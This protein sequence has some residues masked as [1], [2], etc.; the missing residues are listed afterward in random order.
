MSEN[1][2]RRLDDAAKAIAGTNG[3]QRHEAIV[4]FLR[5]AM[6]MLLVGG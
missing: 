4:A 6:I 2:Q 1:F 3:E 5:A